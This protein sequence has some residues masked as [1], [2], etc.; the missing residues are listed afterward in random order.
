[1]SVNGK[2]ILRRVHSK[3]RST[4]NSR[5]WN[6]LIT[7]NAFRHPALKLELKSH[8]D[9]TDPHC[10]YL[11]I[12]RSTQQLKVLLFPLEGVLVHHSIP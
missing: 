10:Q 8:S 7:R 11:C 1:M 2:E 5:E 3:K 6:K 9:Q 4:E 12:F